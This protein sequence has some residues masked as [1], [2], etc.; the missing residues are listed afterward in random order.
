MGIA[1]Q[2][3]LIIDDNKGIRTLLT[4]AFRKDGCRVLTAG[5]GEE[6][7]ELVEAEQPSAIFLDLRLPGIDGLETLRRLRESAGAIP[8][9]I[10]SGHGNMT[11]TVEAAKNGAY[12][13]V[14]K[15]FTVD[16]LRKLIHDLANGPRASEASEVVRGELKE[17][18]GEDGMIGR[19]PG[20]VQV[21]KTIGHVA[22]TDTP[23]LIM[24]ETGTG[25]ELVARAI[26][27]N[28][29]RAKRPFVAVDCSALSETLLE[30]ELFGHERGA[31]TG[32]VTRKLGK[33]EVAN[34]G[35]IFLDEVGNMNLAIQAELLRVL[36]EKAVERV[37]GITT[38]KVDARVLAATNIDLEEAVRERKFRQDLYYRLNVVPVSIP[39]LRERPED[40]IL[41]AEYFLEKHTEG[42]HS[43]VE[44][45]SSEAMEALERYSWPG[46]VREL[47]NI[48]AR[49]VAT[50]RDRVITLNS[51]PEHVR[52]SSASGSGSRGP[53]EAAL[54][55]T[56]VANLEEALARVEKDLIDRALLQTGGNQT[57]ASGLLGISLR[58]FRYRLGKLKA[59]A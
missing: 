34:G 14:Q 50:G 54:R 40:I 51:L 55:C 56:D 28:S 33:F 19:N 32:A 57:Q 10:M 8:V 26:H 21:Y 48:I 46:N 29:C 42:G 2:T 15:P 18:Y 39:P 3:V 4:R 53:V 20:M 58:S 44:C 43:P 59:D 24:G 36:Q 30:S 23:V 41:L 9:I 35:T 47:E 12:D 11:T 25:K 7:L 13:V 5:S 17:R 22:C 37:G 6:G 49:A 16:E 31:F 38:I 27:Q 45:I 52:R 1:E